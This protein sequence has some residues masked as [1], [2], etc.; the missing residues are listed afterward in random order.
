MKRKLGSIKGRI[1]ALS[2]CFSLI[3]TVL[4]VFTGLSQ[5]RATARE[6][7]IQST[8]FNL[9]LVAGIVDQNL[10]SL[11]RLRSSCGANP[12]ISS[13]L[14]SA[15]ND[16]SGAVFAF[17]SLAD[18]VSR[19]ASYQY[20][21]RFIVTDAATHTR[22]LQTGSGTTAGIPLSASTITRL[23]DLTRDARPDTWY[24]FAQDPLQTT[25]DVIFYSVGPVM[26]PYGGADVGESYVVVSSKMITDP[27]LNYQ[28]PEQ[29]R[30]Y[31]DFH[32]ARFRLDGSLAPAEGPAAS[33][34]TDDA[35]LNPTTRVSSYRDEALGE[36]VSVRCPVGET[37]I[38]LTQ[39]L[40]R[41]SLSGDTSTLVWQFV[42]VAAGAA[43]LGVVV[44]LVLERTISRPIGKLRARM[45]KIAQGDFTQDPSIEWDNELGDVG[46]GVNELSHSVREL[47]ETRLADEKARQDLE[48]QMLQS[49]VNPHF[50]YNSLNSIK[51]MATI[52]N[53]PG[54]AEMTTALARLLKNVSKGRLVRITLREE[55]S[56]L[57]DYF[58]IQKYRYGGSITLEK[59]VADEAL[60]G[61]LPRFTLQ[62][63]LENAIFHGI[64]PK[65][66]AGTVTVT[67]RRAGELL[68]VT[69]TDDGVGLD[70]ERTRSL[71]EGTEEHGS[72]F[73]KQFGLN[74][75]HRRIQYEFGPEY[76]LSIESEAGEYTRVIAK[77]PFTTQPP[78]EEHTL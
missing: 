35:T 38:W 50:L 19:T 55:L 20:L 10:D 66:G 57:D 3:I 49:Q 11:D 60:D 67:A 25:G 51:W 7:L 78:K 75:V 8:E 40:S 54:I 32:D 64:E 56:L 23:T 16:P 28:P 5:Y 1:V 58:T 72:G 36:T 62:P 68:V 52:Q 4:L 15:R 47:M 33:T 6:N 41:A 63:L 29:G 44:M 26:A 39:D 13:Y 12:N 2:V 69:L 43:L 22:L 70:P 48:Y 30:L 73:F 53:A 17:N 21:Q 42:G 71:L 27:L 37:G 61:L 76:G 24:G 77:M 46:R 65:G 14:V 74:A 34:P 45:S 18:Q 59:D 9:N 31:I